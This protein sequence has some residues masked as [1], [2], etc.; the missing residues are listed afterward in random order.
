MTK[1]IVRYIIQDEPSNKD[2]FHGGGH[3]RTAR[4]LSKAIVKFDKGDS[5]IGLDG[6]W[7]SGKSSVVEMAARKLEEKN[8]NGKKLYH[9]FT[10]DIWKSQGSGFRRSYLEHLIT[11][12]KQEFPKKRSEL[13]KI[14]NQ[15]HGKTREI[16]TNNQP[17]LDWY[18]IG[19]LVFLPFLPLYYFWAKKV[20]DEVS[21]PPGSA[22]D[23]L[24]S[25]PFIILIIFVIGTLTLACL[26]V[27]S[28]RC[29]DWS[30]EYKAAISRLLLISS[31]QHQDHKVV[32]KVREIDPND[33]EFHST[34]REILGVVQSEKDRVVLVLDNIDRLPKKEIKEYW[35]LVRS[36]FSRIHGESCP[37]KN[38]DITAIVPYDRKL[39][40]ANVQEDEGEAKKSTLSSLASRELFSKTFDEVLVVAPPVLSNAR[41]F[42]SDKLEDALPDQV[43]PDDRFRTYRIFCELLKDEGGIT[44]PRQI[45]SFVNDLSSLYELHDGKFCLPTIAAY[46]AHQDMLTKNPASLNSE[47]GINQ[48]IEDLSADEKLVRNLAAMVFNVEEN[49][50]FQI[51][52]DE[53]IAKAIIADEADLLIELSTTPGFDLRIEDVVQANVDEWRS[54]GELGTAIKNISTL[55]ETYEGDA[56][57]HFANAMLLGFKSVDN[58]SIKDDEYQRYLPV[59][60]LTTKQS[61][62]TTVAHFVDAV[63][64]GIR[65]RDSKGFQ[66]GQNL[67]TFLEAASEE[68]APLDA[69]ADLRMAL[70]KQTPPSSPE[71]MFGLS[72]GITRAGF[73]LGAFGSTK[74]DIPKNSEYFE[75][76]FVQYPDLAIPALN[77]FKAHNLLWDNIWISIANACLLALKEEDANQDNVDDLLEVVAITWQ[78]VEAERRSEIE[79]DGALTEGEFFRNVGDGE[80]ESSMVARAN[81][82]FLVQEKLGESLSTP[83][84]LDP[85]NTRFKDTSDAFETFKIVMEGG[86][87]FED[88]QVKII[89][90]KVVATQ[91]A[92][93]WIK[94]GKE[95]P[96][97]KAVSQIVFEV[98]NSE[99]PPYITLKGLLSHFEY[100][101]ELFGDESLTDVLRKYAERTK[102]SEIQDLTIDE[103]PTGF[104]HA[105]DAVGDGHWDALHGKVNQLL[106]SVEQDAWP[107]HMVNMDRTAATLIEKL[108]SSGCKLDGGR[109]RKPFIEVV[110]GVL[111]GQRK[112]KATEGAFDTLLTAIDHGYHEDIW[113]T[114]REK[115][116][117]VTASSLAE[118]MR[119]FPELIENVAQRGD[120][121]KK[122]EK[123]NVVRYLLIPALEGRNSQALQI[124]ISVGYNKLKDFQNAA[125]TSTAKMLD[126]AWRSFKESDTDRELI[127][128]VSEALYGKR[129]TKSIFDPTFWLPTPKL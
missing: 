26:K 91:R 81:L 49:L 86:A 48:K 55:F 98:F 72:S 4:S 57:A 19:V 125:E 99:T 123:D 36:I 56:K 61:R 93:H 126:G 46:L 5:A 31:K 84:R 54:T 121:I 15:I 12:A 11:W 104:M 6:S 14:E 95:N 118:G 23:F 68:L 25:A 1:K 77:Q 129:K 32:Q 24:G 33:Y 40:E 116:P 51:L 16:Q 108:G 28:W 21:K 63:F 82:L 70:R 18:G 66:N 9:F 79:L 117:N 37:G 105:T 50:A 71:Y 17:I 38:T 52:L 8:R 128:E 39:I 67:V 85:G 30:S 60:K 74:L 113:R 69:T 10:F 83:T 75:E 88:S 29:Q 94:F 65:Q 119:L 47:N 35:A 22:G 76:Q 20:F 58:I 111:S 13:S 90:Q 92:S 107:E 101:V 73:D 114:L 62:P 44:T 124:F 112:I 43:S 34:L 41:E 89:A 109:F 27:D 2:L 103:L 42:F 97:H 53:E 78:K 106:R 45:V 64:K 100:L 59:F 7:G 87:E 80:T 102:D 3:E 127:R 110:L 96:E 120:R 122:A 115:M